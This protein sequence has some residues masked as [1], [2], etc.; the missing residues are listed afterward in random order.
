MENIPYMI[1]SVK[2]LAKTRIPFSIRQKIR[3]FRNVMLQGIERFFTV[4]L[5]QLLL[6]ASD[7]KQKHPAPFS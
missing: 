2:Q 5:S 6:P 7:L 3:K 1:N 4:P